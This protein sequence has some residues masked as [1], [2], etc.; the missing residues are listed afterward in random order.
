MPV[1]F[2]ILLLYAENKQRNQCNGATRFK[3]KYLRTAQHYQ[4]S[5]KEEKP[6]QFEFTIATKKTTS[7]FVK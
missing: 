2:T 4:S 5:L 7:S 3:E 1:G 6:L